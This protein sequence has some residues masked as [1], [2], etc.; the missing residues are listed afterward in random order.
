MSFAEKD[1]IARAREWMENDIDPVT[2]AEATILIH[3]ADAGDAQALHKLGQ[4]FGSRLMFGTA[5]LRAR[6]G[7]GP[8]RMNRV[9]V[10]Q[11]AR[12][13]AGYIWDAGATINGPAVIRVGRASA[14]PPVVIIGFD[15]RANSDTFAIDTAEIMAGAGVRAILIRTPVPTPVLAFAVRE[16][17]ADAGIMVTASHNPVGDSGYKV[18][19]GGIHGGAQI[20]SPL[21]EEI[22]TRIMA[23]ADSEVV[24]D[25]PRGEYEIAPDDV[26]DAY[27]AKTATLVPEPLFRPRVAYTALHGVGGDI[28]RRVLRHAGYDMPIPVPEQDD[29]DGSFPTATIP[30]PEEP[31]TLTRVI[32]LAKE[33]GA[34]LALAHDPDA[35][36]LSVT[37]REPSSSG[38]APQFRTLSGNDVGLL[39]AW[40]SCDRA[41]RENRFEG[42][43]GASVVSTPALESLVRSFGFPV[44]RTLS[45]F[46]WIVRV[47]QLIFGF[48]EALGYLVNPHTVR[49]KDGISAGLAVL[50]LASDLH[51]QGQHLAEKLDEIV[52]EH[53]HY[54]S[55][56]VT[57]RGE[58]GNI[59]KRMSDLRHLKPKDI[60]GFHIER[61]DDYQRGR[62]KLPPAN[63]LAWHIEGNDRVMLRPSGTEAKLKVYID[64]T[65]TERLD[66]LE[67]A[68]RALFA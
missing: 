3:R 58:P 5:G 28:F 64:A 23:V 16:L 19:L 4:S 29:P 62:D 14:D 20:V 34:D 55:S 46:K 49:D 41:T 21:D 38:G 37:I 18:Y 66:R 59:L 30:N 10:C 15:A 50:A 45:G 39:L 60:G 32:A 54:V 25:M 27:V 9:V 17:D 52:S 56:Q 12:A 48:E 8:A 33:I 61:I 6:L 35:D 63:V 11:T 40:W 53:G 67:A 65:S 47:P 26:I 24:R 42:A 36:R 13:L 1:L 22:A 68:V 57:L 51:A 2:R 43:V 7:A 31:G 44:V